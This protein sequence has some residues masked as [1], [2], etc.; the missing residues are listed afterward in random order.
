ML[1][2]ISPIPRTLGRARNLGSGEDWLGGGIT[3]REQDSFGADRFGG[4][5]LLQCPAKSAH[6]EVVFARSSLDA[7]H[8][9]GEINE[10]AASVHEVQIKQLLPS[11]KAFGPVC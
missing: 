1:R 10:F 9:R 3:K 7:I 2:P 4:V 5:Q 8:E 6:P 11:H